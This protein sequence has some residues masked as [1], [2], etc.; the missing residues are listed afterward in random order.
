M[1]KRPREKLTLRE[2]KRL[3][4][5]LTVKIVELLSFLIGLNPNSKVDFG[6][7]QGLNGFIPTV[8]RSQSLDVSSDTTGARLLQSIP[9]SFDW[10]SYGVVTP[11]KDQG[12]CGSCWAFAATAFLETEG[13][14]R[15]QFTTT[16]RL[17]DQYLYWCTNSGTWRCN[18]GDPMIA[19]RYGLSRGMP[20]QSTY[21][22]RIGYSYSNICTA[23]IISSNTKFPNSGQATWYYST[24]TRSSDNS[25]IIELLERALVV[26]VKASTWYMYRPV[27]TDPISNK[28]FSC[29]ET[30]G[31]PGLDHA[32]LLVGYTAQAWIIKNSWGTSW[33]DRGYIYINRTPSRNCGMGY[34]WGTVTSNLTWVA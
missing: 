15:K 29:P 25:I 24:T 14:R 13:I 22:Y 11:V 23:P 4:K 31:F 33:G 32:V 1:L 8:A 2:T 21:P 9:S 7:I 19:V 18:G 20:L 16:T 27:L 28:I 34:Y 17:S 26:A 30:I 12:S 6:L 5:S 10:T 3:W